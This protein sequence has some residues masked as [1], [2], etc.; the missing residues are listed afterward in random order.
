M[1]PP[2]PLLEQDLLDCSLIS[3]FGMLNMRCCVIDSLNTIGGQCSILYPDKPIY[4]IP[5]LKSI[6][7]RALINRLQD[8]AEPF[9]PEYYLGQRISG[10]ARQD[11]SWLLTTEDGR[12]IQAQTVVIAAGVG[13]FSPHRPP[14][15]NIESFE[16]DPDPGRGVK[17]Q[18]Q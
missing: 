13:V 12:C 11:N 10:L 6:T 9:Q 16:K 5:A 4:D 17:Y 3:H 7:G 15:A 14:I 8:Q 1:T 18:C 2:L